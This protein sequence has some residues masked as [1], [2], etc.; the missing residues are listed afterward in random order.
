[1][2][3]SH[4]HLRHALRQHGA[5]ANLYCNLLKFTRGDLEAV[6]ADR[7][8]L[9]AEIAALRFALKELNLGRCASPSHTP[10]DCWGTTWECGRCNTIVC[11]ADGSDADELCDGCAEQFGPRSTP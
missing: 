10:A 11:C 7:D 6:R 4:V 9:H 3:V 2:P 8:E 1:M 5:A